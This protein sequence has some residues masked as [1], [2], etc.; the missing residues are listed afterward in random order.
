MTLDDIE[1]AIWR[2]IELP[3]TA[4]MASYCSN[5]ANTYHRDSNT[6]RRFR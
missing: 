6:P 5:R 3:L 1:P 2:R 4:P